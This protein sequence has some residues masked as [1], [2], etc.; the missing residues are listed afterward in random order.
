MS[1]ENQGIVVN[2]IEC[3]NCKNNFQGLYCNNCGQKVIQ[4]RNTIKHLF[5][6]IFDS[7]DIEKGLVY[8]AKLLFANPGKIIN[9][10]LAG[11]TKDFY[12]PL[13]YLILIAGL[14]AFFV[15][16][17]G[18]FDTSMENTYEVL[19]YSNEQIKFQ[20]QVNNYVKKFLN[21]FS[22]LI[23]PFYSL[24][25]KWVFKK[26]KQYFAEHLIIN[27]YL[28]AQYTILQILT[29]ITV[30]F[31]PVLVKYVPVFGIVTFVVYY[32]YT[33]KSIYKIK[34]VKSLLRSVSIFI[35]GSILASVFIIV[36]MIIVMIILKLSGFNLNELIK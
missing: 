5:K 21:I 2:E 7:F 6:L 17:L 4:E 19:D 35:L 36:T 20:S 24:A 16:W 25:S 10:Y 28:F 1:N 22:I 33:L 30:Y 27:S 9:E 31:I 13:K 11:R 23:L 12:N 15:I 29:T 26:H 3:K 32:A 14:N 18:V 8:T 34:F